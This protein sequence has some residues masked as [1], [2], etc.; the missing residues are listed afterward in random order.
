MDQSVC[1]L[2]KTTLQPP[3]ITYKFNCS[4][5]TQE[6]SVCDKC[7]LSSDDCLYCKNEPEK[8]QSPENLHSPTDRINFLYLMNTKHNDK[9]AFALFSLDFDTLIS[10][11]SLISMKQQ[12]ENAMINEY[13]G[14]APLRAKEFLMTGGVNMEGTI[15]SSTL[16]FRFEPI[17]AIYQ[18]IVEEMP[19]L[20]APRY[21]HKAFVLEPNRFLVVGGMDKDK[22][23]LKTCEI[24]ENGVWKTGPELNKNRSQASGFIHQDFLYIFGGFNGTKAQETSFERLNLKEL[25]NWEEIKVNSNKFTHMTGC[26]IVEYKNQILLVGGSNGITASLDIFVFDLEKLEINQK[27]ENMKYC[28]ANMGAAIIE[29]NYIVVLGGEKDK[30]SKVE[31]IELESELKMEMLLDE[32]GEY[33]FNKQP[34]YYWFPLN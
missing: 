20:L 8:L 6:L 23:F 27:N 29:N 13:S 11:T 34:G 5:H 10:D 16:I 18:Y 21:A 19:K 9:N 26:Q 12:G 31:K 3:I 1:F 2:C 24:F 22:K 15:T 28:R 14:I 17:G 25:K 4:E 33:A 30:E 7:T 32:D